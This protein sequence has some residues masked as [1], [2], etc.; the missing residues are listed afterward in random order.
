MWET[1]WIPITIGLILGGAGGVWAILNRRGGQR[2]A[3]K[4]PAPPTWPEMWARMEA[5]EKRID[6]LEKLIVDKDRTSQ[7]RDRAFA[8]ILLAASRQWPANAP[9]PIFDT[10]DTDVLGDTVPAEWIKQA[11]PA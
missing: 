2:F 8:N 6:G 3:A 5:Q 11:R 1:F 7:A 4:H 10:R 9:G